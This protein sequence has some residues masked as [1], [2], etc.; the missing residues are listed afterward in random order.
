MKLFLGGTFNPVHL[1]HLWVA[2]QCAKTF[3][4]NVC[5]IPAGQPCHKQGTV[6]SFH[7]LHMLKEVIKT[8]QHTLSTMEIHRPGPSYTYE[9]VKQ[10]RA[11][12]P[13]D[14]LVW[15]MGQDAW[16]SFSSWKNNDQILDCCHL[17]IV[18]RWNQPKITPVT[19]PTSRSGEVIHLSILPHP[20]SSTE[21]RDD[22]NKAH[23][24]L[25][26]YVIN[27]AQLHQLY[28]WTTQQDNINLLS[29]KS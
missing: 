20:A 2:D 19:I 17:L 4:T 26:R 9:T 25:P 11:D 18:N 23:Q 28:D 5:F 3:N 16:S 15:I 29:L 24:Y 21:A 27:Y 14:P 1:G 7:R 12:F 13:D 10:L 8:T 6:S 22:L